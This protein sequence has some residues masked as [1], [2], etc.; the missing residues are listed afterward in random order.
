MIRPVRERAHLGSPLLKFTNNPNESANSTVKHWNEF[1]R[2]SWPLF[3]QKLQ[4]LVESQLF[5]ADKAFYGAGEYTLS[6]D[7]H[8]I[9]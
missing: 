6:P 4:K 7:S 8:T 5:E 2:N 9:K 3:V 1:K